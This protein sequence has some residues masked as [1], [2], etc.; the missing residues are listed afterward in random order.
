M[1]VYY[2]ICTTINRMYIVLQLLNLMLIETYRKMKWETMEGDFD[3]KL[4]EALRIAEEIGA[5]K[6]SGSE[7]EVISAVKE[8]EEPKP[9]AGIAF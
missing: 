1:L 6:E 3:E 7:A 5:D 4:L 8:S 9:D 2:C